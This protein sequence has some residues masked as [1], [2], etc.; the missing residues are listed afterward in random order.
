[1]RDAIFAF[2]PWDEDFTELYEAAGFYLL[3][4]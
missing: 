3:K 1:M 4:W 2:I